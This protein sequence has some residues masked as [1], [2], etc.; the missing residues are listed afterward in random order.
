[1]PVPK[2]RSSSMMPVEKF[3][4]T[5]FLRASFGVTAVVFENC[6]VEC[7]LCDLVKLPTSTRVFHSWQA[8]HWPDHLANSLPQELHIKITVDFTKV[9]VHYLLRFGGAQSRCSRPA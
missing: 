2:T 3:W 6:L 8:G 5:S 1:M 9:I 7:D 4:L